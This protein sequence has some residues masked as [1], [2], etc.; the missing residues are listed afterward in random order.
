MSRR[1]PYALEAIPSPRRARGRN[2][3]G[4]VLAIVLVMIFGLITA[5]YAFQRRA[6]INT[7]IAQNRLA[8][9]EADALAR[10]GLRVA[11]AVVFIV[12][13][14]EAANDAGLQAAAG[15]GGSGE[16]GSEDDDQGPASGLLGT[17]VGTG[18]IWARMGDFPLDLGSGRTLRVTVEDEGARLNL[19]ALVPPVIPGSEDDEDNDARV[20]LEDYEDAEQYLIEVIRY[21]VEGMEGTPEENNYD[22]LMIAQ[23]LIDYMD[24]DE[25]AR[26]GRSE[27]AY[28]KDLDPPYGARN[29]PF[30]SFDEIGLVE[31]VDERLLGEMRHYLT[32]H[33]IGS[34]AGINLNR[35]P[36]WVLSLV[37]TGTSGDRELLREQTVRDIWEIR[38]QEKI[39]CEDASADPARCV[40]LNEVGNGAL[41]EGSF[42]PETP[43]PSNPTVFRVVAEAQVNGL[44]RRIEA[45]YDTRPTAGPQLLSW[46]RL[47]GTDS[48]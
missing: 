23:N 31:G 37:Y 41:G 3:Q 5:V 26:N 16:G 30:T 43:L 8:A 38:E 20:E 6:V 24:P 36:P 28:Y 29:G 4:I 27:D 2:E 40:G 17:G 19:N 39:L 21:I 47:R 35:A 14:K 48:P 25:T 15:A 12:R 34:T 9:A 22:E 13:L 46:R 44:S 18:E 7:T 45:V 33:P 1:G 42:Y 32:V 11:E 10:G